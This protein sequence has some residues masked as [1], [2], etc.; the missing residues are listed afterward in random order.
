MDTRIVT[1]GHDELSSST[2]Y[3]PGF[4]RFKGTQVVRDRP[5]LHSSSE[6]AHAICDDDCFHVLEIRSCKNNHTWGRVDLP[7]LGHE[8]WLLIA[9][10][11]GGV[12]ISYAH[13]RV[14]TVAPTSIAD[15]DS[16]KIVF[17]SLAGEILSSLDCNLSVDVKWLRER[18]S[19]E[20]GTRV[21][22]LC[23]L[24]LNSTILSDDMRVVFA[25]GEV[26]FAAAAPGA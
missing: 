7:G 23:L 6:S 12:F 11:H 4:Y 9:N 2:P 20:L 15:R 3:E 24:D 17:T 5:E 1:I 19:E 26:C 14:V 10:R 16:F 22:Q 21:G 13:L 8:A 18:L 25:D